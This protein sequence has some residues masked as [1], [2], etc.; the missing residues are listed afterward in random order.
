MKENYLDRNLE[1]KRLLL[2][3]GMP[4]I[5]LPEEEIYNAIRKDGSFTIIDDGTASEELSRM[6]LKKTLIKAQTNSTKIETFK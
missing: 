6:L 1:L 3:L 2:K 4:R 5:T